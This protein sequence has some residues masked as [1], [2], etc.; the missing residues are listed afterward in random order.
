MGQRFRRK[1]L[2]REREACERGV[3]G[4]GWGEKGRRGTEAPEVFGRASLAPS[5]G[6]LIALISERDNWRHQKATSQGKGGVS[7]NECVGK[8]RAIV[9]SSARI[10][11]SMGLTSVTRW[12]FAGIV[13]S[14]IS[15]ALLVALTA[16]G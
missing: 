4:E 7:A 9:T 14:R 16:P 10:R 6:P 15:T 11:A 13:A 3:G 1:G 5:L 12:W 2:G 8:T